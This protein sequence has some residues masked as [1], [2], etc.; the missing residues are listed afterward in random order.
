MRQG[1]HVQ[2]MGELGF[3]HVELPAEHHI[4]GG[5]SNIHGIGNHWHIAGNWD[6][7]GDHCS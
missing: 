2:G 5:S 3:D 6:L 1:E 4:G 7:T